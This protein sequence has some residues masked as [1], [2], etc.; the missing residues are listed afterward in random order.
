MDSY[1]RKGEKVCI[2]AMFS[3]PEDL[4]QHI[5]GETA[6]VQLCLDKDRDVSP[7]ELKGW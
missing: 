2:H 1:L 3:G 6:H 4:I 7:P 5:A